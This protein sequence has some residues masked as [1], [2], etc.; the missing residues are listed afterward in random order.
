MASR[1]TAWLLAAVMAL[2][3][4]AGAV[5]EEYPVLSRGSRDSAGAWAVFSL[6]R[7]LVDLKYLSA[8]PDG[9]YGAGTENAVR[10]FQ[11]ANG[12][13]ATGIADDET[14]Q[15]LFASA[16][17]TDAETEP[18]EPVIEQGARSNEVS[19]IQSYML[20]WGF[21]TDSPDGKYGAATR[22][23][24]TDFMKYA[25][26]DM[27]EYTRARRAEATPA[28]TPSPTPGAMAEMADVLDVA[29]TPEPT[30]PADGTI[31]QEWFDYIEHGF[32]PI[33]ADVA[34]G[35]SGAEVRRMQ[36]RLATL[37]YVAAGIDGGFGA[38]TEVALK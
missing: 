14:Q 6:Q 12:L 15:L 33:A 8:E 10:A 22:K 2:T 26:D 38:H 37:Q 21:T 31:T 5:A 16:A 35:D 34:P 20:Q 32:D 13:E 27:L 4:A 28:P 25:Y 30:I 23:A 18:D 24:L 29:I 19:I 7:K 3:F 9:V 36:R 1:W 17:E 11:E